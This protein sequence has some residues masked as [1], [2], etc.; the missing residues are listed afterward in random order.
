MLLAKGSILGQSAGKVLAAHDHVAAGPF[1]VEGSVVEMR[2]L[3][4]S[5][6]SNSAVMDGTKGDSVVPWNVSSF[7]LLDHGRVPYPI[8]AAKPKS[9][10][11]QV[12][13]RQ[14]HLLMQPCVGHLV[15]P[16]NGSTDNTSTNSRLT[17][18]DCIARTSGPSCRHRFS[19]SILTRS[20]IP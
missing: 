6:G 10:I 12:L 4:R 9:G 5:A 20:E 2:G 15:M 1:P 16:R 3:G 19:F 7:D 11:A 8:L 17:L 14:E 18:P 13:N